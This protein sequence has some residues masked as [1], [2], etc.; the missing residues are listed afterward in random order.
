MSLASDAPLQPPSGAR[1]ARS[2]F[3]SCVAP[4][5]AGRLSRYLVLE[6]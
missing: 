1:A 4:L 6:R 3:E 2:G 5:A